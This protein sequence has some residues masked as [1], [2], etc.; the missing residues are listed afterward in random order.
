M[1]T[2]NPC[3]KEFKG[4]PCADAARHVCV[5]LATDS[6]SRD[7]I[8]IRACVNGVLSSTENIYETDGV[9]PLV[10]YT[11]ANIVQCP[12]E[13]RFCTS[14]GAEGGG[15]GG[16]AGDASAA[17]QVLQITVA[18]D[19]LDNVTALVTGVGGPTDTAAAGDTSS[20]SLIAL[21]K[22]HLQR[23]TTFFTLLPASIGSKADADS[24][25][26]T[27]ST[28]DKMVQ[29]AIAAIL[30]S[31]DAGIPDALG[32]TT[33]AASLS[34]TQASDAVTPNL[35]VATAV[36]V[37]NAA[38]T[39]VASAAVTT[40]PKGVRTWIGYGTTSA[41]AGSC[42]LTVEGS[43]DGTVWKTIGTMTLT[44]ATTITTDTNTDSFTDQSSFVQYRGRTASITGTGAAVTLKV[45]I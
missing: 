44:L 39:N 36:T 24:F 20:V 15:G 3:D 11:A 4:L 30:V 33:K 25:A 34:V 29:A 45:G 31:I 18:N 13:V 23:W 12:Q 27:A 8:A 5:K 6:C 40:I 32:Q 16:G 28:E 9:T 17:N 41:G 43:M 37:V 10:G 1:S 22:R 7:A 21:F 42:T 2:D 26:V 14:A 38:T 35:A 19:T